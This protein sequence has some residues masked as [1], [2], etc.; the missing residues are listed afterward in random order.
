ATSLLA[1]NSA[2]SMPLNA[3]SDM[4]WTFS[5]SPSYGTVRPADRSD[6]SAITLSTGNL[7]S[8]RTFSVSWPTIP[9]A[10]TTATFNRLG[11]GTASSLGRSGLLRQTCRVLLVHSLHEVR[12]HVPELDELVEITGLRLH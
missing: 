7:R 2:T 6:A 3:S 10:P 1:A 5:C 8:A 9:V 11:V 12:V 4:G